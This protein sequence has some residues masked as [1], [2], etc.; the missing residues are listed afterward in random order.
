VPRPR[1][2]PAPPGRAHV[3]CSH[4][5]DDAEPALIK[6]LQ[7]TAHKDTPGGIMF[8]ALGGVPAEGYAYSFRCPACRRHLKIRKEKFPQVVVLLAEQQGTHGD[9]PV[10]VDISRIERAL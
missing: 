5:D 3:V 1:R 9:S 8:T 10:L 2:Q 6:V 7:M 4:R